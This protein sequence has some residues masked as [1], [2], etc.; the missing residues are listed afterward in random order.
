MTDDNGGS[1]AAAAPVDFIRAIVDEDIASNKHH[2]R[3]ATRFPPEP[4]G[5]LHIGHAKA[6]CLDF[7]V[8]EEHHG[9]CNL[10]YDDTNPTKEDIEYVDAIKQDVAWLGF[11]WNAELYASDYFEQLY[12]F[13]IEL[14]NRGKAYVDSL[15]AH[16]ILAYRGTLTETGM[17]SLFRDLS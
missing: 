13:A 5:Y 7:G 1:A 4:N 17:K 2:G 3:V 11:R 14:I 12:H 10:R 9:T 6:I 16:Q 15:D 8:A